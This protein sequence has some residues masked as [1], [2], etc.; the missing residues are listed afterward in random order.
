VP[1]R[2]A[3]GRPTWWVVL[4][5]SLALMALVAATAAQTVRSTNPGPV[6]HA[7]PPRST[8]TSTVAHGGGLSS[9]TVTVPTIGAG[10]SGN[11][12][13]NGGLHLPAVT[14]TTAAPVAATT[15]TTAAPA[16]H[17]S[18]YP[19]YLQPPQDSSTTFDFNGQGPTRISATWSNGTYLTL[20][21]NCS[22]SAAQN[23]GGSSALSMTVPDAQ[24][25]C[26]ATLSE[27]TSESVTLSYTLTIDPT[28]GG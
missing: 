28:S 9:A 26:Q 4:A 20:S 3:R 5:V 1:S 17:E 25:D 24:G 13:T 21:M 10:H 12:G 6:R 18:V 16:S 23:T 22:G 27:P 15:T 14:T 2:P 11:S 19:G 8:T 7:D